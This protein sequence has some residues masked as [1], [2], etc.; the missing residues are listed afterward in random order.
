MR[1]SLLSIVFSIFFQL[2]IGSS[3][4]AEISRGGAPEF[5][6]IATISGT[7]APGDA[8]KLR[9]FLTKMNSEPEREVLPGLTLSYI[10]MK[11][12]DRMRICLDSPGGSLAE[13]IRMADI[14]LSDF[15]NMY[16]A[17]GLG[18]A[19]PAG[20]ICESACAVFFMAGGENTE[21]DIGR[22][23]DRILHVD[24]RLGFHSIS[25][26]LPEANYSKDDVG[27][28]FALALKSMRRLR[29]NGCLAPKAFFIA[30]HAVHTTQ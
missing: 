30:H 22:I 10:N 24:G 26:N 4:A 18:T 23:A 16:W 11:A 8:E 13:A 21:S 1:L 6:C 9:N 3:F 17:H 28:A 7:I 27:K 5:N 15:G 25:L 29:S 14:L 20:A 2:S 19:V 12:N